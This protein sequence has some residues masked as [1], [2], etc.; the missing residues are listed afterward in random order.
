MLLL[1]SDLR[2]SGVRGPRVSVFAPR[3]S[4]SPLVPVGSIYPIAP[5]IEAVR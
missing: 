1:L 4:A 2:P 3:G 5:R